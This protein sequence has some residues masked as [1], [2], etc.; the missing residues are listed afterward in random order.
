M[1]LN[2]SAYAVLGLI[3]RHGPLTPSALTARVEHGIAFFWPI[4]RPGLEQETARLSELGLLSEEAAGGDRLF[5]LT[6]AGERV[7]HAWLAS[8][9]VPPVDDRDPARV[10]LAFADLG[11]AGDLVRLARGQAARHE[12]LLGDYR[13]RRAAV[14][15]GDPAGESRARILELGIVHERAHAAFWRAL[16]AAGDEDDAPDDAGTA[17]EAA[18]PARPAPVP[19]ARV[20]HYS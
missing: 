18:A 6:P 3:A 14:Q 12:E 15:T 5:Q 19:A 17:G 2:T 1:E 4:P 11:A 7:L 8:P 16:A 20:P 13:D 10:R 9:G